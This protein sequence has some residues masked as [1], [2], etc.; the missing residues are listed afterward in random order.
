[1]SLTCY[2][3][4]GISQYHGPMYAHNVEDPCITWQQGGEI[5]NDLSKDYTV[6]IYPNPTRNVFTVTPTIPSTYKI[7]VASSTGIV[8]Y[9]NEFTG[10][11]AS[12]NLQDL[13]HGLYFVTITNDK[14]NTTTKRIIKI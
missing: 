7:K 10:E 11:R 1:M 12:V 4:D 14:E 13:P 6:A 5:T 2:Y 8:V 3:R 9:K